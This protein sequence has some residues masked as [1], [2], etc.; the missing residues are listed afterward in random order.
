MHPGV[1]QIGV[2]VGSAAAAAGKYFLQRLQVRRIGIQGS[3]SGVA[4]CC[5][6]EPERSRSHQSLWFVLEI[7]EEEQLVLDDRTT[8]LPTETI[9]V[10]SRV[11]NR[12]TRRR[13]LRCRYHR[14]L[15][16]QIAVLEVLIELSVERVGSAL[17]G[18]IELSA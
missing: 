14:I 6:R 17:D 3:Q 16:I 15:G 18:L 8:D 9:V 10:E 11:R 2:R 4:C 5:R 12:R 7:A 1:A 13:S